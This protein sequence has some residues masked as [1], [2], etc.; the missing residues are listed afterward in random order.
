MRWG[1]GGYAGPRVKREELKPP[2]SSACAPV[3]PTATGG[4]GVPVVEVRVV[5][6]LCDGGK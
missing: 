3:A 2:P 5:C 1:M 4:V 6:P